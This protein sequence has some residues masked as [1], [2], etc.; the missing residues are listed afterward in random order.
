MSISKTLF[1]FSGRIPRST[2]WLAHFG[3]M[4]ALII[5]AIFVGII[6]AVGGG[7]R[8]SGSQAGALVFLLLAR[9][10]GMASG[11]GGSS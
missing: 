2:Y 1:S 10:P 6:A 5:Y 4:A 11:R 7:H 3:I 8:S 9:A